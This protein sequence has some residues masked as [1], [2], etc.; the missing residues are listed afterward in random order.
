VADVTI[1]DK[2]PLGEALVTVP[3]C[4]EKLGPASTIAN[5][6]IM[7]SLVIAAAEH[8]VSLGVAPPVWKSANAPGGDEANR[9]YIAEYTGRI[10]HL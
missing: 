2:V 6:F 4:D 5:A 1:D 7:H 8:M 10:R 9:R 3:G